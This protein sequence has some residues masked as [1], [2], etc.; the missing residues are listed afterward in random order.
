MS[1]W[2]PGR[3]RWPLLSR[4]ALHAAVSRDRRVTSQV[5][6]TTAASS[7]WLSTEAAW[8]SDARSI[9]TEPVDLCFNSHASAHVTSLPVGY[10]VAAALTS[11]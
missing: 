1:G 6:C 11:V 7:L 2:T 10:S 5:T 8:T 9:C 3:C 4:S